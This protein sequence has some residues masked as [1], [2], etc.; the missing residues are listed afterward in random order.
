MATQCNVCEG[1]GWINLRQLTDFQT[2]AF[3]QCDGELEEERALIDALHRDGI[4]DDVAVCGCCGDGDTHYDVP[5]QHYNSGDPPGKKG[6][7]AYNG[8][9]CEC[10]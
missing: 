8:G 4:A 3:Y 6:P 9:Y 2:E 5:G 7:Y 1:T 10:H